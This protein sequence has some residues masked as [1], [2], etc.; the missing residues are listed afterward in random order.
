VV[1]SLYKRTPNPRGGDARK[2]SSAVSAVNPSVYTIPN[3]TVSFVPVDS[4]IPA[5]AWRS[6]SHSWNSFFIESFIDELA[7][8]SNTSPLAFRLKGLKNQPR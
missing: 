2:D 8:A 5:G 1:A 4:H 6:V 7:A 3:Q